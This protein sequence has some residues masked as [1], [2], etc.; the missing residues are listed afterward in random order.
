M[1]MNTAFRFHPLENAELQLGTKQ[2]SH[3]RTVLDRFLSRK[4]AVAGLIL[5]TVLVLLAIFGPLFCQHGFTDIISAQQNGEEVLA[6]GIA[7]T[8]KLSSSD[9]RKALF[10]GSVFLFGT[11]DLGR[12]LWA[13]TWHGARVSLLIA[14]VTIAID[15][16]IGMTYGLVSGYVGG[17]TDSVMQ[18]FIEIVNSVPSLDIVSVL[19]IFIPKG[20]G[21]VI[22]S[23]A[24]TE[25][26][27]MSKIA[28]AQ[29]LKYKQMEFVK[30]SLTLGTSHGA[31]IFRN[32]L[33][34]TMGQIVTQIMFSVPTA[35]FTEA[36][37]SFIGVGITLPNCSVGSLIEAGFSNLSTLPYQIVPPIAVLALLMIGFSAVG[38]G[39]QYAMA[40]G[41]D[42]Q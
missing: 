34:N 24:A 29:M 2:K 28:R 32:I 11:D 14:F 25:W 31:I 42:G 13:R 21:L 36:F 8:W 12:D 35:I 33:P 41:A 26:I 38:D 6:S 15:V 1:D 27:G 20:I 10:N 30:A 7:P 17:V 39:L 22:V 5:I 18:R 4:K 40:P 9:S 37:L 16:V 3:F 19:A 23:L